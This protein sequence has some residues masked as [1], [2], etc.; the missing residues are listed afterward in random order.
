[1]RCL[2]HICARTIMDNTTSTALLIRGLEGG[3]QDYKNS[4]LIYSSELIRIAGCPRVRDGTGHQ[5]Q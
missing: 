2:T 5:V 1:M 3:I 4:G